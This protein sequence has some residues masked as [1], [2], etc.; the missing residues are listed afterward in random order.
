[1]FVTFLTSRFYFNIIKR[2]YTSKSTRE[3]SVEE[4]LFELGEIEKLADNKTGHEQYLRIPAKAEKILDL[5][6]DQIPMEQK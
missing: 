4:V 6:K 2:L 5:F 1:M 3:Y